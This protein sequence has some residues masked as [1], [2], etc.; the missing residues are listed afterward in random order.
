MSAMMFSDLLWS[1]PALA[2]FLKC[3]SCSACRDTCKQIYDNPH[4]KAKTNKA[5]LEAERNQEIRDRAQEKRD[6][7]EYSESSYSLG[8]SI[9][10]DGH[11]H[12]RGEQS[13]CSTLGIH[14]N[15]FQSNYH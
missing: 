14:R 7:G 13:Y 11:W 12:E 1:N 6:R 4:L 15:R 3:H 10:S 2:Q 5:A 9:D 8:F